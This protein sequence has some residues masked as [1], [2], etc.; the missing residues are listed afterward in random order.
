MISI[1]TTGDMNV[2]RSGSCVIGFS[3]VRTSRPTAV[4]IAVLQPVV[5]RNR[6]AHGRFALE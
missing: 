3:S 5:Y 4:L 2:S 1:V 6:R